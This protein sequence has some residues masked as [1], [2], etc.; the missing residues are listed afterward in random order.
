[1]R[2]WAI[3]LAYRWFCGFSLEDKVP[4]HSSLTRIRDRLGED[5]FYVLF[6]QVLELCKGYELV[7]GEEVIV[8]STLIDANASLDSLVAHDPEQARKEIEELC[9]RTPLD[10]MPNRKIS[11]ETHTSKTDPDVSLAHKKRSSAEIEI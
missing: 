3:N 1:M 7:K 4:D 2:R 5:V 9:N 10:P 11:N 8:D 6:T